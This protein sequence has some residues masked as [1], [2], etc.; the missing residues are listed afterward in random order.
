MIYLQSLIACR[1]AKY[2]AGQPRLNWYNNYTNPNVI[3]PRLETL[4]LSLSTCWRLKETT[5]VLFLS[6]R[7]R[8]TLFVDFR[9]NLATA[10]QLLN[11][12]NIP[13]TAGFITYWNYNY[14]NYT[15]PNV[16][17]PR[18]ETLSLSLSLSTC[19]R[20]KETTFVLFLSDRV[21]STSTLFV[22]FRLSLATAFQLLNAVNIPR[23]AGFITY[24][25]KLQLH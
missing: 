19:W 9:L 1:H 12:V 16:I 4:S 2:I 14:N 22:D 11:A 17:E 25:L 6:D 15:N 23:T 21:R 7:V 8:S 18:L 24:L 13:R 10:F 3:E 20:L 5:F